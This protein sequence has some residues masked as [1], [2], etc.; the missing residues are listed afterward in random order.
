VE[1]TQ[2]QPAT[3]P[4]PTQPQ[5]PAQTEKPNNPLLIILIGIGCIAAGALVGIVI[6]SYIDSK[7]YKGKY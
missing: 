6:K 5:A 7:K 1:T 4:A 3:D 2:P